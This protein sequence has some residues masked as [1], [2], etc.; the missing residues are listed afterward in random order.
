MFK[1]RRN[2][3]CNPPR[4]RVRRHVRPRHLHGRRVHVGRDDPRVRQHPRGGDREHA[5]AAAEIQYAAEAASTRQPVDGGEA[6]EGRRMMRGAE[7]LAGVDQDC[8]RPPGNAPPVVRPV[9]REPAGADWRQGSL[10]DRHPVERR[11]VLDRDLR[12]DETSDV[13]EHGLESVRLRQLGEVG[14]DP[15][16]VPGRLEK[17]QRIRRRLHEVLHCGGKRT[18]KIAIIGDEGELPGGHATRCGRE[19]SGESR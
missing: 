7:S 9:H 19:N 17:R 15:P 3:R 5:G 2:I 14:F 6:A 10:R 12:H 11:H 13:C 16:A 1:T 18:R 8:I 4:R